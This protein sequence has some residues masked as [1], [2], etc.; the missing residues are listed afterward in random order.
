MKTKD[1][2]GEKFMRELNKLKK[3]EIIKQYAKIARE[4]FDMKVKLTSKK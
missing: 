4:N 1:E 2:F 3:S